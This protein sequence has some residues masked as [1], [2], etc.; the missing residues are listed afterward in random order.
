MPFASFFFSANTAGDV[1]AFF[2]VADPVVTFVSL[3]PFFND[4]VSATLPGLVTVTL[5]VMVRF[6]ADHR[7]LGCA[8]INL[9]GHARDCRF[10]W[11]DVTKGLQEIYDVII[12]N[13]PFHSGQATDVGLGRAFIRTAAA[14]LG[15][16]GR[17]LMVANRQLPY[18]SLLDEVG[19]VWRH[20]GGDATFKLLFADKR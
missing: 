2:T 4:T 7:A 16:G 14:A 6:E 13:P 20:A 10:H 9:A 17:L 19:L 15:R 5:A 8:R 12:M 3:A 1:P 18:E 11:H